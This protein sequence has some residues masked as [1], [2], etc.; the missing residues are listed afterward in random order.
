MTADVQAHLM[1]DEDDSLCNGR[2]AFHFDSR[3]RRFLQDFQQ[4]TRQGNGAQT[5]KTEHALRIWDD[6]MPVLVDSEGNALPEEILERD[7]KLDSLYS[8]T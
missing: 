6:D 5:L 8:G 4:Q 2:T 1:N 3:S 7:R